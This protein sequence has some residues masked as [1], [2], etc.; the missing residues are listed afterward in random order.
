MTKKIAT[1]SATE[2]AAPHT[3]HPVIVSPEQ[4]L[5]NK[6]FATVRAQLALA[7]FDVREC[8]EGGWFVSRYNLT[9]FCRHLEDLEAMLGGKP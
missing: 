7:G 6:R 3:Q 2:S 4:T 1:D 5:I 9:K 8:L